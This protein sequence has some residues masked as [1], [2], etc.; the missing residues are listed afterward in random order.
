MSNPSDWNTTDN[1]EHEHEDTREDEY[2]NED[3]YEQEYEDDEEDGDDNDEGDDLHEIA[4][5]QSC[6]GAVVAAIAFWL[7]LA[8]SA[9]CFGVMFAMTLALL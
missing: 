6:L 7:G 1:D 3:E 8:L 4:E 2:M 5:V 9:L